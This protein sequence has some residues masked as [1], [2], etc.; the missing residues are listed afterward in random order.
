MSK[1][2]HWLTG[3][4][5]Q[6]AP[7]NLADHI[8]GFRKIDSKI[9]W[10]VKYFLPFPPNIFSSA[11]FGR[12][13]EST[14]LVTHFMMTFTQLGYLSKCFYPYLSKYFWPNLSKLFCQICWKFFLLFFNFSK[15]FQIFFDFFQIFSILFKFSVAKATLQSQMSVCPS[16]QLSAK[17][18][19]SLKSLSFIIHH[20]YFIILHSSFIILPSFCDF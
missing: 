14:L 10:Y 20:P 3:W 15:C 5:L 13:L 8:L 12:T 16:V 9:Y 11:H 6:V 1:G 19:N 7:I 4:T 18:L 17:P 2:H